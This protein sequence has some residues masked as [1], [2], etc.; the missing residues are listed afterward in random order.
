MSRVAAEDYLFEPIDKP[1]REA[2]I[3]D[4]IDWAIQVRMRTRG[5][6][7]A[8]RETGKEADKRQ[9]LT[10]KLTPEQLNK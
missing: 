6:E 10:D 9:T 8:D 3:D 5:Y 1:L 2:S 7:L 4:N